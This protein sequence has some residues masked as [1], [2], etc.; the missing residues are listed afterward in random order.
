MFQFTHAAPLL[1]VAKV[2]VCEV[3][4]IEIRSVLHHYLAVLQDK[5]MAILCNEEYKRLKK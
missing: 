5:G 2:K 1:L 4:V 3:A